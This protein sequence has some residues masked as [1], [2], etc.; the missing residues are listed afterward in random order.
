[1]TTARERTFSIASSA[2]A[3]F[4]FWASLYMY[5]PILPTHARSLGAGEGQIGL[6]LAS[7]GLTQLLFRLPLGLLSDR[8]RRKKLFA[9]IGALLVG[10]SGLVMLGTRIPAAIV[11]VFLLSLVVRSRWWERKRKI[12]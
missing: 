5:V 11:I 9:L 12:P 3:I 4:M 7:Y 1:M 10:A 8:L 6:I 2:L